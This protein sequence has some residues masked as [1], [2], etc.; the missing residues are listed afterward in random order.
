MN[1]INYNCYYC[2]TKDY[3]IH[4][5]KGICIKLCKK[6]FIKHTKT[7]I[8]KEEIYIPI[9]NSK[10]DLLIRLLKNTNIKDKC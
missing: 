4:T 9:S 6:C 3:N 7:L 10:N 8:Q 5:I 2:K 1:Q